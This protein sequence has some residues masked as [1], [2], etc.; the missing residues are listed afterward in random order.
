[1]L[2]DESQRRSGL[3]CETAAAREASDPR[4]LVWA[5]YGASQPRSDQPL[6]YERAAFLARSVE[7]MPSGL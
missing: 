2:H 4:F 6:N 7:I 1:M 3:R 5:R